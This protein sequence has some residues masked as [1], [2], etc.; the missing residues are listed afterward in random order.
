MLA[1]Q[2]LLIPHCSLARLR[3]AA[4][5]V[6][7]DGVTWQPNARL[8][9]VD[10]GALKE[11]LA[12]QKVLQHAL[13]T[14]PGDEADSDTSRGK[15]QR[16]GGS[17]AAAPAGAAEH[18][19]P[20]AAGGGGGSSTSGGKAKQRRSDAQPAAAAAAAAAGGGGGSSTS[21]GK[22][23]QRRSDAQPAAAAAAAA[24]GA[25]GGSSSAGAKPK[26]SAVT[27]LK[28]GLSKLLNSKSQAA[29]PA[30]G[31]ALAGAVL[32]RAPSPGSAAH[33]AAIAAAVQR[34]VQRV[35]AGEIGAGLPVITTGAG[36]GGLR[37]AGW[38]F[39]WE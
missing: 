11:L 13:G 27:A 18:S 29:P 33:A 36:K 26:R 6:A 12:K 10:K 22:A 9:K 14:E 4:W 37:V 7:K 8:F 23:K 16:T 30:G 39:A 25:G 21:G 15:R 2:P 34:G 5:S 31:D 32:R 35:P 1:H 38:G 19:A 24:A 17:G 20:A 28:E 3:Q